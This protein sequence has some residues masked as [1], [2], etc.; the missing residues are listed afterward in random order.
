VRLRRTSIASIMVLILFLAVA[1]AALRSASET[2]D[3]ILLVVVLGMLAVSVLGVV[4][5]RG[6][7][8]AGWLGFALFGWGYLTLASGPW[9]A[10]EVQPRLPTTQLLAYLYRLAA[11]PLTKP[12]IA[13]SLLSWQYQAQAAT[14]DRAEHLRKLSLDLTGQLPDPAEVASYMND[15]SPNAD[16][17]AIARL[18]ESAEERAA[19]NRRWIRAALLGQ[20]ALNL[21][22][23]Q[24]V[25][26]SLFVLLAGLVG[27]LVARWFHASRHRHS[28]S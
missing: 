10:T 24:H 19:W 11:E 28:A 18:L 7:Q 9:F 25:G 22:H 2:W 12:A 26:H 21:A 5:R 20:G 4:Y 3:G 17:K 14:L 15:K 8:R 13:R 16:D 1:S 27:A 6:N 23:L